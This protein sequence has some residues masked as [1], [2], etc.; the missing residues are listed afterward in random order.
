MFSLY[1]GME[2]KN[3][4]GPA[5]PDRKT[6]YYYFLLYKQDYGLGF[7]DF[8]L[9]SSNACPQSLNFR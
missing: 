2:Y 8:S 5:P 4:R 1:T 6:H 7:N 3:Y 9:Y